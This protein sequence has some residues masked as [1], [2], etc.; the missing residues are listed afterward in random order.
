MN[1][2]SAAEVTLSSFPVAVLIRVSFI[3][4]LVV[5]ATALEETFKVQSNDELLFEL[6]EAFIWAAI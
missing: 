3:I 6:R 4:A 2:S 5:F 1:L